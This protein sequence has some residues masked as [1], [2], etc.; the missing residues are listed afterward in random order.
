MKWLMQNVK[1][2]IPAFEDEP[3]FRKCVETWTPHKN[4]AAMVEAISHAVSRRSRFERTRKAQD[5]FENRS[6][7]ADRQP[8]C[9]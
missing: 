4:V 2:R 8:A 5:R 9:S 1:Q 3:N 7:A 6:T